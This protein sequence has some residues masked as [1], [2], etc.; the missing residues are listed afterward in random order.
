MFPMFMVFGL[1]FRSGGLLGMGEYM[2]ML[3]NV[4]NSENA[5]DA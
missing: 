5:R 1:P 2:H 4:V 3:H